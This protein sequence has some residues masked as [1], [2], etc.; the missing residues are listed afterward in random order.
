MWEWSSFFLNI[1]TRNVVSIQVIRFFLTALMRKLQ[2]FLFY[3]I[4][5]M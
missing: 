1:D 5:A 2:A 4:E 3:Y